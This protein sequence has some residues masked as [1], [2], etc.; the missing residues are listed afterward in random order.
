MGQGSLADGVYCRGAASPR[1]GVER[2]KWSHLRRRAVAP[3][4]GR[5]NVEY[6]QTPLVVDD[7]HGVHR[8]M[9]TNSCEDSPR[10]S[11]RARLGSWLTISRKG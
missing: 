6:R 7:P 8:D 3:T 10:V 2:W 9:T 1:G 4:T 11:A 5:R